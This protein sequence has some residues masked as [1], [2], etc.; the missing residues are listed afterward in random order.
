MQL[1]KCYIK[2][3]KSRSSNMRVSHHGLRSARSHGFDPQLSHTKDLKLVVTN[4]PLSTKYLK[5]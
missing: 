4:F 3:T 2:P 5:G 1:I